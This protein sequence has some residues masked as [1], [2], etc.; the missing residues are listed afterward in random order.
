MRIS[1]ATGREEAIIA[2][3]ATQRAAAS[4][5]SWTS[6]LSHGPYR[7]IVVFWSTPSE[8]AV[9]SRWLSDSD[10]RYRPTRGPSQQ[11]LGFVLL[12]CY[13]KPC[14]DRVPADDTYSSNPKLALF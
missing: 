2:G 6:R 1:G 11:H 4:F 10:P 7:A 8:P 12:F 5:P 13:G 3:R 9:E 14:L